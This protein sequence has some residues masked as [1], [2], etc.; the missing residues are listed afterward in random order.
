MVRAR[1]ESDLEKLIDRINTKYD[2]EILGIKIIETVMSDYRYRVIMPRWA[3]A[4]YLTMSADDIDYTNVKDTLAPSTDPDRH[5][6]MVKCW[7]AM[8][9]LQPGARPQYG[10]GSLWD[11]YS[12]DPSEFCELCLDFHEPSAPCAMIG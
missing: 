11:V 2:A 10:Y 7:S 12:D 9:A 5:T 1:V 6:A 3:W 8:Y 4:E